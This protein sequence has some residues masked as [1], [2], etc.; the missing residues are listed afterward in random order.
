MAIRVK[1]VKTSRDRIL[2]IRTVK[3][4]P[5]HVHLKRK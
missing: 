2:G 3:D 4:N 5:T 1:E